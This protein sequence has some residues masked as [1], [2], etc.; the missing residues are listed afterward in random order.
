MRALL[1]ILG[2]IMFVLGAQEVV[3]LVLS[4]GE[5]LLGSLSGGDGARIVVSGILIVTG[6]VVLRQAQREP[7]ST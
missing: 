5:G 1:Q 6:V 3:R 4:D 7:A 2:M